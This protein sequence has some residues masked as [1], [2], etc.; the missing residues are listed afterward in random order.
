MAA[1]FRLLSAP[2]LML[3]QLLVEVLTTVF[4]VLALRLLPPG[5]PPAAKPGRIAAPFFVDRPGENHYRDAR[6]AGR[7]P[8][9]RPI[10][11]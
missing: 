2:D 10:P 7:M 8:G 9:A 11:E 1:L 6:P 3:T 4:F 5:L